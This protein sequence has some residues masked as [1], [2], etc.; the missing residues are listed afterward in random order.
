MKNLYEIKDAG[1]RHLFFQTA[2]SEAQALEIA[3]MTS[4]FAASVALVR[5]GD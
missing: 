4:R 3:R 1:G 2:V 5:R